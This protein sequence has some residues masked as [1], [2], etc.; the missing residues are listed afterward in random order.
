MIPKIENYEEFEDDEEDL[1][2]FEEEQEPS[3]TYKMK[4]PVDENEMRKCKFV[5]KV[6]DVEALQ[7]AILKIV[8]TERYEYEI[9]SWDYGIET[10]DLYGMPIPYV[11]SEIKAR[12]TDAILADDRFESVE[13]FQVEQVDRHTIHCYFTVITVD[14]EEIESEYDFDLTGGEK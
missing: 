5:G 10:K 4:I 1:E 14:D 8:N 11:M 2:D 3:Y 13:N 9:Y 12:V 7:Q 6:D